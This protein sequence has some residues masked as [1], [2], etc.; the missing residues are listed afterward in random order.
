MEKPKIKTLPIIIAFIAIF[1]LIVLVINKHLIEENI[2]VSSPPTINTNQN[3]E[4]KEKEEDRE[5]IEEKKVSFTKRIS[6]KGPEL[7]FDMY[8]KFKNGRL[9]KGH[10][11]VFNASNP[12]FIQKIIINNNFPDGHFNWYI[13]MFGYDRLQVDMVDLNFDGYLDL[14]LLDNKGAT[15]NNWYAS[16]LYDPEGG[17]FIF[18]WLLSSQSGLTVDPK[19]KQVITYDTCGG[20]E[21]FMKYYKYRNGHYI[22][23]KIEWTERNNT[24]EPGCFKF[25]GIPIVGDIKIDVNRSCDPA[26]PGFIK[27]RVKNVEVEGLSGS[28]DRR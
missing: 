20:C 14:R 13:E 12:K 26:L 16:F 2:S 28:L 22:L 25:T 6:K 11:E 7:R 27:K 18:N 24:K 21:E 8:G 17:K 5:E 19:S 23:S 4:I 9:Y 3:K 10:M 15:G 1:F